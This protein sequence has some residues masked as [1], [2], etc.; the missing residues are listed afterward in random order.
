MDNTTIIIGIIFYCFFGILVGS[1]GTWLMISN[2]ETAIDFRPNVSLECNQENII[3]QL[4]ESEENIKQSIYDSVYICDPVIYY[5]KEDDSFYRVIQQNSEAR[6]Y[7]IDIYDCTEFAENTAHD[8]NELGWRAKD[9]H[10]DVNCDSDLFE[11]TSC[12]KYNGG[13]RIVRV[14]KIY[15]ESVSGKIIPPWDYKIYG[16]K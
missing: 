1:L 5:P 9:I 2:Q 12:E 11:K 8:L 3:Q 15:I 10:T 7:E 6:P 4:F 14:D 13:H 16:I